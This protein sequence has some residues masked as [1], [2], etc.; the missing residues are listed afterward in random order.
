MA[1]A[2]ASQDTVETHCA[3]HA[4]AAQADNAKADH[5]KDQ[6]DGHCPDHAACGGKC[7]CLGLTA[8]LRGTT[9]AEPSRLPRPSTARI[10]T[11]IG[12]PAYIPPSPPPRV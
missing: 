11:D 4:E 2:K 12:G 6:A 10:A 3:E 7:L 1:T 5:A 9:E 8:V